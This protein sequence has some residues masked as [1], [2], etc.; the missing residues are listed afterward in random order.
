MLAILVTR[1]IIYMFGVD[2]TTL[3]ITVSVVLY[4][5]LPLA[6]GTEAVI[7]ASRRSVDTAPQGIC[8]SI[9]SGAMRHSACQSCRYM[10]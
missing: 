4:E 7:I 8:D 6:S 5:I 3:A 10:R 1:L 2:G 9:H